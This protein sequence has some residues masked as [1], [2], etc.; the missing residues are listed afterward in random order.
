MAISIWSAHDDQRTVERRS[1]PESVMGGFDDGY[2]LFLRHPSEN[3]I[4][5]AITAVT[6]GTRPDSISRRIHVAC[7][8]Q[9][10]DQRR[11]VTVQYE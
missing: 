2:V 6:D 9:Y 1:C 4:V 10:Y 3:T 5:V 11:T 8:S 7:R